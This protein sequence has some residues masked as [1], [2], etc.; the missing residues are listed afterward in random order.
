MQVL[1]WMAAAAGND[2]APAVERLQPR[3]SRDVRWA[4]SWERGFV[5]DMFAAAK[6]F[7]EHRKLL[8]GSARN[9][10]RSKRE[11]VISQAEV[12]KA[13]SLLVRTRLRSLRFVRWTPSYP[14]TVAWAGVGLFRQRR[15]LLERVKRLTAAKGIYITLNPVNRALLAR[16][17]NRL[18]YAE[19]NSATNDQ[20]ILR[21]CWLLLDV[22]VDRPSGISSSE[23]RKR[24]QKKAREIYSFL[25]RRGWPGPIAA[26]SGNG[27]HLVIASS[28]PVMMERLLE[29]LLAGLADR[30]DGDGVKLDRTVLQPVADYQAV[31]NAGLQR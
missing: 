12:R 31:R 4:Q 15:C 27:Y 11:R 3:A 28:C 8:I 13:L 30:F 24:P 5:R 22:D 17:A 9:T 26:D 16:R 25:K 6:A 1:P 7:T 21:R 20:H 14:V 23:R 29:Q 19:K 2:Q 10:W 18:D